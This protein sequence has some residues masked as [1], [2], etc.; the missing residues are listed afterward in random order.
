MFGLAI[1]V[2][3][4]VLEAALIIG[5]IAAATRTL[6]NRNRWLYIGVL[7]GL[8]G[9]ALVA[10]MTA[11]IAEMAEGMGQE[12]LNAG[13]LL[14][15]TLMLAWH[16]IWMAKHGKKMAL[17]AKQLGQ[18]I[19]SGQR[20]MSALAV[21]VALAIL[22][23]GS[24]TALFL[25]SLSASGDSASGIAGG[26]LL[27]LLLGVAAGFALFAG[28]LRIPSRYFFTATSGLI[29]M[30]AAGLAGHAARYLIQA[31]ALPS[32]ASPTWD[33]SQV[34]S[35][36]S[37]AGRLLHTL[38]GYD[39]SPSGMQVVFY[40]FTLSAIFVAMRLAKRSQN[41]SP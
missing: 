18:G 4:E 14:A 23:E 15:A 5:I 40:L 21:V 6:P 3:R 25:Y 1:I 26:A 28:M 39:A 37:L 2:F 30:M 11:Q 38:I 41:R 19:A 31:D 35:N 8:L 33:S 17:D 20:E 16:V 34:L 29:V 7:A 22:R 27:G 24:E 10:L 32:L 9:A 13:I 12:W 36:E